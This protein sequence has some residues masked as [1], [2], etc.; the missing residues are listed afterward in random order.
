MLSQVKLKDGREVVVNEDRVVQYTVV[1]KRGKNGR[2]T[3]LWRKLGSERQYT[4]DAEDIV[5][6]ELTL[7]EVEELL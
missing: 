1:T 5:R 3:T 2:T 6:M 7:D 4:V